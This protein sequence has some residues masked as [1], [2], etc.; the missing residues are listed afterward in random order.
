MAAPAGSRRRV[1]RDDE[2]VGQFIERL[3]LVLTA[4]GFQRMAA[5]A[6]AALLASESGSLTARELADRLQVS[7][8]SVSGAVSYLERARLTRRSRAPG[9]RTDHFVL[10]DDAWYEAIATRDDVFDALISAMDD[11]VTAVGPSS[12]AGERIVETREF[13][14]YLKIEMPL[15]VERWRASRT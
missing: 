12:A 11:G 15:M 13:F 1:R 3:A 5:R 2:A 8:A 10:G 14:D 9:Q 6:F 4:A 7:P